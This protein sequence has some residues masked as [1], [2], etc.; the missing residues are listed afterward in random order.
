ML[1]GFGSPELRRSGDTPRTQPVTAHAPEPK[2]SAASGDV[3]LLHLLYFQV[4]VPCGAPEL[5]RHR[6]SP[7]VCEACGAI[8]STTKRITCHKVNNIYLL[9]FGSNLVPTFNNV[10]ASCRGVGVSVGRSVPRRSKPSPRCVVLDFSLSGG[11]LGA[12]PLKGRCFADT[13]TF[14]LLMPTTKKR[15]GKKKSTTRQLR[16]R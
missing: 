12:A 8:V 11:N 16:P 4:S 5:G 6:T 3:T 15:K 7:G 9:T 14:P 13:N 2:P 10:R 1:L